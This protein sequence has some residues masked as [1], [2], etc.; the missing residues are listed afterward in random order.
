MVSLHFLML[1]NW[2][3]RPPGEWRLFEGGWR[4][5]PLL[6]QWICVV[7]TSEALEQASCQEGYLPERSPGEE[8]GER[9]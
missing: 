8:L 3:E 5:E 6:R 1:Q 4:P 7:C 9:G 2:K